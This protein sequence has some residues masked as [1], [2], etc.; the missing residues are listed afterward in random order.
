MIPEVLT[1]DFLCPLRMSST[2]K[3]NA[4]ILL[5]SFRVSQ[6]G[7]ASKDL[8]SLQAAMG[9]VW[10]LLLCIPMLSPTFAAGVT[11]VYYLGIREVDWNY[12]PMGRNV[13]TNQSIA[14]N[15]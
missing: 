12:A 13:F 1:P 8:T 4:H 3:P 10:W 6:T 14:S 7:V 5:H 9:S 11:R 15:R 2:F